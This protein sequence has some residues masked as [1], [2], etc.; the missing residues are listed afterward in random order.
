MMCLVGLVGPPGSS[1]AGSGTEYSNGR[2]TLACGRK[3]SAGAGFRLRAPSVSC[4]LESSEQTA[5]VHRTA[6][7]RSGTLRRGSAAADGTHPDIDEV[8]HQVWDAWH[9]RSGCTDPFS[10]TPTGGGR[11]G[12][13]PQRAATGRV[14][15][16][17]P[18]SDHSARPGVE[19]GRG[20]FAPRAGHLRWR[21]AYAQAQRTTECWATDP[22]VDH[23]PEAGGL[24]TAA[25]RRGEWEV[26]SRTRPTP[27]ARAWCTQSSAPN[28]AVL[29]DGI[30]HPEVGVC[31]R[32]GKIVR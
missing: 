25:R 5:A 1:I 2:S 9:N 22:G 27:M 24:P 8:L 3:P 19:E 30:V 26:P 4:S 18:A 23:L 12:T 20:P 28:T 15:S 21:E 14:R 10:G 6:A 16:R 29:L 13:R 7:T 31:S 32:N 11:P 17:D